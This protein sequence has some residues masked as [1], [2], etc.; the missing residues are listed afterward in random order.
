VAA[1]KTPQRNSPT[2]TQRAMRPFLTWVGKSSTMGASIFTVSFGGRLI[3]LPHLRQNWASSGSVAPH[4][5]QPRRTFVA[6]DVVL[7][8][9]MISDF[10]T[11]EHRRYQET[12][13]DAQNCWD[14]S[15]G[16]GD[17][18]TQFFGSATVLRLQNPGEFFTGLGLSGARIG[19][20]LEEARGERGQGRRQ[21]KASAP[22]RAA[23]TGSQRFRP[24]PVLWRTAS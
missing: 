1:H 18:S 8:G 6:D 24:S 13:G 9:D 3:G 14:C 4:L 2:T 12:S 5:L 7:V 22:T 17:I 20:Y 21:T 19:R 23:T 10:S 16:L 11:S 15:T